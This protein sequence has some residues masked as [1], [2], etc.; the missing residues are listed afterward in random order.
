MLLFFLFYFLFFLLLFLFFLFSSTSANSS[1]SSSILSLQSV[2]LIFFSSRHLFFSLYSVTHK[3]TSFMW[4]LPALLPVKTRQSPCYLYRGI[5]F[6]CL[7]L[8]YPSESV[9]RSVSLAVD[10]LVGVC[11]YC[12]ASFFFFACVRVCVC[13]CAC[14]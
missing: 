10:M 5:T 8:H 13:A 11:M 4:V 1:S 3:V 2:L 12:R 9:G 7:L 6:W 14:A